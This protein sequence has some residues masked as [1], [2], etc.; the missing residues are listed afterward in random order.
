MLFLACATT[1]INAECGSSELAV[2]DWFAI[3]ALIVLACGLAVGL[4]TPIV[5]RLERRRLRLLTER[6]TYEVFLSHMQ[7]T[8]GDR[9]KL[10]ALLLCAPQHLTCMP[11]C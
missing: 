1:F 5:S 8:A 11:F 9:C 7:K 4:L 6:Q 3:V 10:L 2:C